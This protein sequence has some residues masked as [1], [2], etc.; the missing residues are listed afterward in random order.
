[1]NLNLMDPKLIIAR[2][3]RDCD[4]R[5]G[6]CCCMCEN[7]GIRPQVCGRNLGPST[8]GRCWRMDRDERRKRN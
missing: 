2:C 6:G 5:G 7:A 1:M 3:R 8:S 4:H